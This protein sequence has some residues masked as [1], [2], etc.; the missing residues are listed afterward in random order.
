MRK[1]CLLPGE[2]DFSFREIVFERDDIPPQK[3]A[4]RSCGRIRRLDFDADGVFDALDLRQGRRTQTALVVVF[5]LHFISRG[6]IIWLTFDQ[7]G[8]VEI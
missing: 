3:P 8:D 2:T 7:E 6:C 4:Q 1:R 5:S